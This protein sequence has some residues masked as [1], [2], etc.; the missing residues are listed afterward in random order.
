LLQTV[1]SPPG[2]INDTAMIDGA[3][4]R[5]FVE[6]R[7]AATGPI[8]LQLHGGPGNG[9]GLIL[10]RAYVGPALEARALVAYLHQRGVLRSPG[11]PDSALTI[12]NHV[13]DVGRTLD[14]LAT[15]FPRRP[16]FLVG[17]SWGGLLAL[18][19][20][21]ARPEHVAGVISVSAPFDVEE[22]L[23]ASYAATLAWAKRG[24]KS[25]AVKALTEL[26]PPPFSQMDQQAALSQWASSGNGGIDAHLDP[27]IAFGRAPYLKPDP[28]WIDAQMAIG[29]AMLPELYHDHLP[30]RIGTTKIPLLV[31]VG[32]RDLIVPPASLRSGFAR[33]SGPKS[34]V[35]MTGSHHLPFADEPARFVAF[36]T[37]FAERKAVR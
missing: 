27:K 30:D 28:S 23:E 11:V 37:A 6:L 9:A 3:G 14:Y 15:R 26:G 35:Q 34:F 7:G 2:A 18:H 17:H 10:L 16:I 31:I 8:L 1:Q 22:S 20:A 19:V 13:E 12:A 5:L 33:W 24:K 29:K 4:T 21:L 25:E 36:V 32:S